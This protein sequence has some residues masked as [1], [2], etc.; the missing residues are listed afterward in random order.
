MAGK[1]IVF[2]EV[3]RRRVGAGLDTL[4]NAVKVTLGPRGR[5]VMLERSYGA[6][7]VT[8]DG[9]TV[10]KEID[11]AAKVENLGVQ[12]VKEVAEKTAEVAG[13][14]T[15]TATVLTQAIYNEGLK[16]VSAGHSVTAQGLVGA[17]P[18]SR[19]TSRRAKSTLNTPGW[20]GNFTRTYGVVMASVTTQP[21]P[22]DSRRVTTLRSF[23]WATLTDETA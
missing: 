12:V 7:L 9:V 8:K 14:G 1:H 15:T 19:A 21:E 23:S 18:Q 10:A 22:G 20:A 5:N 17:P 4:A 6:P 13:D 2:S 3:A 11:V 16:L